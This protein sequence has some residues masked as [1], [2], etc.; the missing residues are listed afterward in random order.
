MVVVLLLQDG[1]HQAQQPVNEPSVCLSAASPFPGE[2]A[3][4]LCPSML[5]TPGSEI[6]LSVNVSR[7]CIGMTYLFPPKWRKVLEV[8]VLIMCSFP[9]PALSVGPG[10]ALGEG[11]VMPV[12]FGLGI[13]VGIL[14]LHT[15]L[16]LN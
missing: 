12:D 2:V 7:P 1:I 15:S 6:F 14:C 10:G 16:I 4:Y 9:Q 3:L 13:R 11:L 8:T 5:K